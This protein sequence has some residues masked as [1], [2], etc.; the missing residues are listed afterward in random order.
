MAITNRERIGK[1]MGLLKE[2][3]GPFVEREF[4]NLHRTR[5]ADVAR[6]YFHDDN[7]LMISTPIKEWDAAALLSLMT[8][9]WN[10]VF[11]QTLAIRNVRWS[12]SCAIG[13]TSGPIR[14]PSPAKIRGARLTRLRVSQ[15]PGNGCYPQLRRN[16]EVRSSGRPPPQRQRTD[17]SSETQGDDDVPEAPT[18]AVGESPATGLDPVTQPLTPQHHRYHGTVRLDPQRVGRDAVQI[19]EEVIVHLAGLPQA[20][21]TVTIEI[22]AR[23]PEDAPCSSSQAPDLSG[24]EQSRTVLLPLPPCAS[25]SCTSAAK[26]RVLACRQPG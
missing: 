4:L 2:G 16:Q 25:W 22:E 15:K 19:A 3:L 18:G 8:F 11:R 17:E 14:R 24:T 7:R 13:G 5:A 21:V 23:L 26:Q 6:Q 9:S 10:D 20:E 12:E 1:A